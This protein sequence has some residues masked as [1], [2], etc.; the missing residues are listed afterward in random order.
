MIFVVPPISIPLLEDLFFYN[1]TNVFPTVFST[2]ILTI[3]GMLAIAGA[4]MYRVKN[5]EG[6]WIFLA[7]PVF[8]RWNPGINCIRLFSIKICLVDSFTIGCG[9]FYGI[10]SL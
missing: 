8:Y 3:F 9:E 2:I 1:I 7:L 10:G 5:P 6:N 4:M